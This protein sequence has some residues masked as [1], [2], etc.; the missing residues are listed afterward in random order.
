MTTTH[1]QTQW[2]ALTYLFTAVNNIGEDRFK[3]VNERGCVCKIMLKMFGFFSLKTWKYQFWHKTGSQA[4]LLGF[5]CDLVS[6]TWFYTQKYYVG[7]VIVLDD[8]WI[9]S[10]NIFTQRLYEDFGVTWIMLTQWLINIPFVF[11]CVYFFSQI[12]ERCLIHCTAFHYLPGRL[13]KYWRLQHIDFLPLLPLSICAHIVSQQIK[14]TLK[15]GTMFSS[16]TCEDL[17]ISSETS[18][19]FINISRDLKSEL[20]F[21]RDG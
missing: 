1:T 8:M 20:V 11:L 6:K 18:I 13:F 12:F 16:Q 3:N 21:L 15:Q 5:S 14:S 10:A 7:Y 19:M 4:D 17:E 2:E 9:Y